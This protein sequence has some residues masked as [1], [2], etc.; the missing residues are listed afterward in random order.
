MYPAKVI[1]RANTNNCPGHTKLFKDSNSILKTLNVVLLVP[2]CPGISWQVFY[3][4]QWG[5]W[6]SLGQC[7]LSASA[8]YLVHH[9][10]PC[11]TQHRKESTCPNMICGIFPSLTFT[12]LHCRAEICSLLPFRPSFEIKCCCAPLC[13]GQTESGNCSLSQAES[14]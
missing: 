13:A 6:V 5:Q 1:G 8:S 10:P 2:F 7:F 4:V 14:S 11:P 12:A 9:S 3:W